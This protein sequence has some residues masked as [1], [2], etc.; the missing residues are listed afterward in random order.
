MPHNDIDNG[1]SI[2]VVGI[3]ALRLVKFVVFRIGQRRR[4]EGAGAERA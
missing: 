3:A 4:R 1:R 2:C